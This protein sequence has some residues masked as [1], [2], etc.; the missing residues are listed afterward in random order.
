MKKVIEL[1]AEIEEIRDLLNTV[2][3]NMGSN[4][5]NYEALMNISVKM[6]NLIL[7]YIKNVG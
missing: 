5:C 4:D 6:D 2:T 3:A 1:K 7:E